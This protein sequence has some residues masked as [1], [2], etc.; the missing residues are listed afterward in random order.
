MIAELIQSSFFPVRGSEPAEISPLDVRRNAKISDKG[1]PDVLEATSN[2]HRHRPPKHALLLAE[3]D[4][5]VLP[6]YF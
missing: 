1:L 3:H 6:S 5:T 2:H 4:L